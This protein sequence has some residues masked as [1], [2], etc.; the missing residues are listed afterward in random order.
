MNT[1]HDSASKDSDLTMDQLRL[2]V[3]L[4]S[5]HEGKSD[6]AALRTVHDELTRLESRLASA[7]VTPEPFR[8]TQEDL[9]NLHMLK[10][11]QDLLAE[12]RIIH[13]GPIRW[14]Y[15]LFRRLF[16]GTQRRYNE[17]VTYLVRRLYATALLTRY[18]QLRS[19]DLEQ[20]VQ[21]VESQLAAL[22]NRPPSEKPS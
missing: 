4:R 13:F 20:R 9:D 2:F 18:Y 6:P 15:N 22:E 14:L 5:L 8:L 19:L 7:G 17:S 12:G 10:V 11:R 16:F 1:H 3:S 21:A